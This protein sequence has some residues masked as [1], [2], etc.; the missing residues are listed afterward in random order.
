MQLVSP[1]T[2]TTTLPFPGA[3]QDAAGNLPDFSGAFAWLLCICTSGLHKVV[4]KVLS[5]AGWPTH[6][7][8]KLRLLNWQQGQV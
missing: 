1:S 6:T 7:P 3:S 8:T 2:T 4:R 5:R